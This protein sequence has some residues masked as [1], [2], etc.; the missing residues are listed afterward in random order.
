MA[1]CAVD[2]FYRATFIDERSFWQ[3]ADHVI[4]FESLVSDLIDGSSELRPVIFVP[5]WPE[6]GERLY[7]YLSAGARG[8]TRMSAG[9]KLDGTSVSSAELP[10]G[11]TMLLGD[12]V[13]ESEYDKRNPI[14][15]LS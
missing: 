6:P 8:V 10:P 4:E 15:Q 5:H 14:T 11:L 1:V 9:P 7:A 13:D 12:A 3:W 2:R